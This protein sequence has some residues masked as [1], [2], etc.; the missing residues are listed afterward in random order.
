MSSDNE[1]EVVVS[2]D[3]PL[4]QNPIY[5]SA[6]EIFSGKA[7]KASPIDKKRT[8]LLNIVSNGRRNLDFYRCT[9]PTVGL[10]GTLGESLP[11]ILGTSSTSTEMPLPPPLTPCA[12]SIVANRHRCRQGYS[13]PASAAAVPTAAAVDT[14]PPLPSPPSL[15]LPIAATATVGCLR[16][17]DGSGSGGGSAAQRWQWQRSGRRRQQRRR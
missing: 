3:I 7:H 5:E 12:A 11:H 15:S 1:V 9:I 10:Y 8:M 13:L 17:S 14:P 16:S 2:W 4:K 6:K